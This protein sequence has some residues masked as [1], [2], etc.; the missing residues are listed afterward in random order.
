V[1]GE[2]VFIFIF[3]GVA[4]RTEEAH[5]LGKVGKA[6]EGTGITGCSGVDAYGCGEVFGLC[7]LG[8]EGR[9]AI[10]Q[11]DCFVVSVVGIAL[12]WGW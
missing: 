10:L 1:L 11:F 3:F 5:V 2:V 12:D 4:F 6:G 7:I 8:E 9:Y